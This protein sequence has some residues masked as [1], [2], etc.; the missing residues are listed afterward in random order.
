L[1]ATRVLGG[2]ALASMIGVAVA[3]GA[4]AKAAPPARK[5]DLGDAV[6]GAYFG[7][8]ISDSAGASKDDVE[9]T[10]TRVGKNLVQISSD[11][12]RLPMVTVHLERATGKIVNTG[13]DTPF[14]YDPTKLPPHLDVSFHNEVSWSGA[15]R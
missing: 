14:F 5:P 13:G 1:L 6:Q 11:Y 8:V 7:D 9:L 3:S 12:P 4:Y 15:R 2:L 10:V